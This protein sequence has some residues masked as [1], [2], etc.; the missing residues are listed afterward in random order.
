MNEGIKYMYNQWKVQVLIRVFS[1]QK[2]LPHL[3]SL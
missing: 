1:F 2:K 3:V